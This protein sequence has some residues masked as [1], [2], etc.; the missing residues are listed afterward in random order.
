M[1]LVYKEDPNGGNGT[2]FSSHIG[3]LG[4]KTSTGTF[5]STVAGCEASQT[6]KADSA[7]DFAC[8]K[9]YGYKIGSVDATT[10]AE[11]ACTAP[12]NCLAYAETKDGNMVP[13]DWAKAGMNSM[14]SF[15]HKTAN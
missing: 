5:S 8:G 2:K 15:M 7:G 13:L 11:G 10:G 9:F 12:S 1:Q 4:F 14:L 6:Y 3:T